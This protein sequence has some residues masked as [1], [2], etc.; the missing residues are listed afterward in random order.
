MRHLCKALALFLAT[1]ASVGS[2]ACNASAY[3]ISLNHTHCFGLSEVTGVPTYSACF[4]A[5]C[6]LNGMMFQ[7][8]P[9]GVA[10]D[11]Y[12][13]PS[14][15][16]GAANL[17]QCKR[18]ADTQWLGA[19]QP[20]APLPPPPT[21]QRFLPRSLATA[22][23]SQLDLE[24]ESGGA[25]SAAVDGAPPRSIRVPAGG[26]SSDFQDQPWLDQYAVAQ[27]VVYSRVLEAPAPSSA[28]SVWHLAFGAVNHGARISV[29]G[30]IVGYHLGPMMPFEVDVTAA[31]RAGGPVLLTVEA[32]PYHALQGTVPSGFMYVESWRNGTNGWTS[33]SCAGICRYVRLL[34]LPPVRVTRLVTR[35]AVGPPATL[36]VTATLVNESPA[37]IPGGA[38]A[39]SGGFSAWGAAASAPAGSYPAVPTQAL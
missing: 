22:P 2:L 17:T 7:F 19:S 28:G 1:A 30:T 34:E 25:W 37:T 27:S 35:A 38:L 4:S 13:G 29:N 39:L 15:W 11:A 21:P 10:C 20:S 24:D 14:C 9:A 8:C 23:I 16:C 6:G 26:Y 32:F 12:T 36:T 3:S 33:R 31:L 5:C 18:S